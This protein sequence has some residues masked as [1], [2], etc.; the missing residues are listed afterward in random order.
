MEEPEHNP[1]HFRRPRGP[2]R[3][4]PN[5]M[6]KNPK[7]SA[8]WRAKLDVEPSDDS[9][10]ILD[11]FD[12]FRAREIDPGSRATIHSI[13]GVQFA[14][15]GEPPRRWVTIDV[16]VHSSCVGGQRSDLMKV[17]RV[18]CGYKRLRSQDGKAAP[19]NI[20]QKQSDIPWEMVIRG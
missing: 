20:R 2:K 19:L 15:D 11:L 14:N 12:R 6:G 13:S 7:K 8:S 18:M 9:K 10:K 17:F 16:T 3:Q 4:S 1:E 5:G